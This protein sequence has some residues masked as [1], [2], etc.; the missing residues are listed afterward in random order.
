MEKVEKLLLNECNYPLSE[1]IMER[2]LAPREEIPLKKNEILVMSNVIDTNIYVVEDGILRFSYMDGLREVTFGF[3]LPGTMII[4]M[5]SFY[6]HLPVFYQIEACCPSK[7]VKIP[8]KHY[9]TMVTESHDFARWALE[10]AN[11]QLF[12]YEKK[13]HIINGDAKERYLSLVHNRPDILEKVPLKIIASYLGITQSYLS[14]LKK[15]IHQNEQ[16]K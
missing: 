5:H 8:K 13:N 11:G 4:S 12:F 14:R 1:K 16:K 3:A 7:V 9:D 2:F 15:Q 10:M 6:C